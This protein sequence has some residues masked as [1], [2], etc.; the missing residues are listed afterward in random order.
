VYWTGVHH[1]ACYRT[2][3]CI[4]SL[5]LQSIQPFVKFFPTALKATLAKDAMLSPPFLHKALA[6]SPAIRI[7]SDGHGISSTRALR[8]KEELKGVTISDT[9]ATITASGKICLR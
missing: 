9:D 3:Y 6:S 4:S 1:G 8:L 5:A 7:P 2:N